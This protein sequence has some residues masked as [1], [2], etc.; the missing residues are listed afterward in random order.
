MLVGICVTVVAL[1]IG[2]LGSFLDHNLV[3]RCQ[4]TTM[5]CTVTNIV[6]VVG[7]IT[8]GVTA[9]TILE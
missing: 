4:L 2:F 9:G 5:T 1:G 7:S 3:R 6:I 8:L